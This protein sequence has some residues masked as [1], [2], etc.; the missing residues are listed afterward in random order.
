MTLNCSLRRSGTVV[1]LSRPKRAGFL[2]SVRPHETI[3]TNYRRMVRD[4][5][6]QLQGPSL[7]LTPHKTKK[8]V[9]ESIWEFDKV[10]V[11]L[12][13]PKGARLG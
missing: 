4:Q 11:L 12:Q 7:S 13:C 1:H 3:H 9:V 10:V 6:P 5:G 8:G 2:F